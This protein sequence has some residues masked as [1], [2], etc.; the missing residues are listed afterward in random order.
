MRENLVL[1]FL[2]ERITRTTFLSKFHSIN[3]SS[4]K[5]KKKEKKKKGKR[6][7]NKEFIIDR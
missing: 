7:D 6:R 3:F 4:F 1:F 2:F 5:E